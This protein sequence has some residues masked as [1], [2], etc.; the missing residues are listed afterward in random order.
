MIH[1]LELRRGGSWMEWG[2]REEGDKG[3]KKM[4]TCNCIIN[5]IYFKKTELTEVKEFF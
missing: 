3:E 1:G 2:C 4:E 5:K